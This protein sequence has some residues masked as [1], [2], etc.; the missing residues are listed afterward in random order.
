MYCHFLPWLFV[1]YFVTITGFQCFDYNVLWH[2]FL[3]VYSACLCSFCCCSAFIIFSQI[4]KQ[5]GHYLF[6]LYLDPFVCSPITCYPTWYFLTG[7]DD[8]CI[9][10]ISLW[11]S[12]VLFLLHIKFMDLSSM[13]ILLLFPVWFL[14]IF[15]FQIL[16]F[17]CILVS[18][19]CFVPSITVLFIFMFYFK[20]LD[21]LDL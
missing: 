17:L 10:S 6:K 13:S 9:S 11:F 3:S 4:R 2:S 15:I 5:I 8:Q 21:P 14:S 19:G 18:S 16:N 20:S 12:F 1:R 7:H